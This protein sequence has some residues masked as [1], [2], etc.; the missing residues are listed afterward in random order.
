MLQLL[1]L[2][3]SSPVIFK[4]VFAGAFGADADYPRLDISQVS[5]GNRIT[6]SES[7]QIVLSLSP[8]GAKLVPGKGVVYYGNNL[9]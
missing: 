4:R 6:N 1:E 3:V 9:Q 7:G 5:C 8:A 2:P